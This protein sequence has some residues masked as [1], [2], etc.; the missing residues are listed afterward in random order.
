MNII[1]TFS[2]YTILHFTF[3]DEFVCYVDVVSISFLGDVKFRAYED[4]PILRTPGTQYPVVIFSHG[5]GANRT[6]YSSFCA[7]LASKGFF[8]A[9]VE[10]RWPLLYL[11]RILELEKI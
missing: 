7:D 1:F 10:H 11:S 5:L 6:C 2:V 4:A 3:F 9:A 8:V